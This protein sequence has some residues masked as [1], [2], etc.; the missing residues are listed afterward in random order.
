MQ[1]KSSQFTMTNS[2]RMSLIRRLLLFCSIIFL[3]A[4]SAV[5]AKTADGTIE[6]RV[7]SAKSGR[8][9]NNAVITLTELNIKATTDEYGYFRVGNVPEG[10]VKLKAYY[11]GLPPEER[12]VRVVADK[13][14]QLDITLGGDAADGPNAPVVMDPFLIVAAGDINATA[15]AIH[16][17]RVASSIKTVAAVDSFAD[18]SD[19]NAGQ[20]LKLLPG[21]TMDYEGVQANAV[22]VGGVPSS[23]TPVMIDGNRL[24][25]ANPPTSRTTEVTQVS[26]NS[27]S[28]VEVSRS[29]TP[30]SPADAIGGT[31]NMISKSAFERSRPSYLVKAYAAF[32]DKTLTDKT[33][34]LRPSFELNAIVPLNKHVG[35][36]VTAASTADE[37]M[38]YISFPTWVPNVQPASAS[39]PATP[40]TLPYLATWQYSNAP[41]TVGRDSLSLTFDWRVGDYDVLTVGA[42][43]SYYYEN[44]FGMPRGAIM[45]NPGRVASFGPNFTEGAPGAGFVQRVEQARAFTGT[46]YMP[47][48]RWR[49][50]GPV[51]KMEASGSYSYASRRNRDVG[52][53]V[54]FIALNEYMRNVT[55]RFD[56]NYSHERPTITVRNASGQI[57]DFTKIDNFLIESGTLI[58]HRGADTFDYVRSARAF[59]QRDFELRIPISVKLGLDSRSQT[60]ERLVGQRG[61]TFIG[62]DGVAGTA[63]DRASQWSDPAYPLKWESFGM[64]SMEGLSQKSIAATYKAHP[65]YFSQTEA[66]AVTLY[67]NMVTG[68]QRIT[69]EVH[70]MYLR[71]DVLKLLNQ[72]LS[73]TGGVRYELTRDNGVGGLINPS[74]IY[75]RDSNGNIVR[76]A[77][78]QPVV[79]APLAT[80]AGTKLAYVERGAKTNKSYGDIYPSINASYNFRPD[81]IG[82]LSYAKSIARPNFSTI[83]PS[84]NLPDETSTSRTITLTNPELKPWSANSYGV[85]LEYYFN[86]P[87]SGLLAAR[88][89]RRDIVDFWG[90]SV[91]PASDELLAVYGIDAQTYGASKGYVISSQSNAG[92]ARVSGIEFDYRQTLGFLPNWASGV[93]VFANM[94][95]QHLE[96]PTI[97]D[98]VGFV[99]KT[100]NLGFTYNRS[101]FTLRVSANLRGR[102]RRERFT[103]AGVEDGTYTYRAP[104]NTIDVSTEFRLNRRFTLFG[105]IRNLFNAPLDWERYGASTPGYARMYQSWDFRPLF[106]LGIKGGF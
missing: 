86:E 49:H 3:A 70:A 48:L 101:R 7:F 20:L 91:A 11:T 93:T 99:Q 67:R 2:T 21:V 30:D 46:T 51:W 47:S 98:F 59:A 63:D 36:A 39:F 31:V 87:S 43:Y 32:R 104:F 75:Q 73:V 62:A 27:L 14:A 88:A 60:R 6:G 4:S 17:Q 5:A 83:L 64:P 57:V 38:Q 78:G 29:P 96:G 50:T 13:R 16:E 90:T 89:F 105:T 41:K 68:S 40:P 18:I 10:A 53:G 84:L 34:H 82:R 28:R 77:A 23:S 54:G 19:G 81:L 94:T 15:V 55:I 95:L 97:A 100:T 45:F 44:L 74:L 71:F 102:E 37:T 52:V 69:E 103:G 42:M 56:H 24:A 65:E 106:S 33:F 1:N 85:S 12:L 66:Q 9:L 92:N 22:S 35:F 72:R 80:L 25:S 61:F 26:I 79:I 76:N 8:Y 58:E